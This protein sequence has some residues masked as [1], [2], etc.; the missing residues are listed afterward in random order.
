MTPTSAEPVIKTKPVEIDKRQTMY[1]FP[2]ESV[3]MSNPGNDNPAARIDPQRSET[4]PN[5]K[6]T[7]SSPAPSRPSAGHKNPYPAP[8]RS[9][10][11]MSQTGVSGNKSGN[12]RNPTEICPACGALQFPGARF[13]SKCG[14]QMKA[15]GHDAQ[16]Q[17]TPYAAK[18]PVKPPQGSVPMAA[19]PPAIDNKPPINSFQPLFSQSKIHIMFQLVANGMLKTGYHFGGND[20]EGYIEIVPSS[21]TLYKKSKAVSLAFG[22]IGSAIEGKGKPLETIQRASV[23]SFQKLR[24]KHGAVLGYTMLLQDGRVFK[25]TFVTM[26]PYKDGDLHVSILDRFL[27]QKINGK[28][29]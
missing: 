17:Q 14:S 4:L 15:F 7:V 18:P 25:M 19:P 24:N 11:Q 21:F 28:V 29:P 13:C 10:Q 9:V 20:L 1:L 27:T 6:Q 26:K 23:A 3:G 16:K 5:N 2:P 8:Q 12:A 22:A